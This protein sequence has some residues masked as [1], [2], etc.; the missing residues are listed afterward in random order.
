MLCSS[1]STC[2]QRLGCQHSN[3]TA[4]AWPG[5]ACPP[6]PAHFCPPS[7]SARLPI[8][9]NLLHCPAVHVVELG[10]QSCSTYS[11]VDS[12]GPF[13][14]GA[15]LPERPPPFPV[16]PPY[17][18]PMPITPTVS[19]LMTD[20]ICPLDLSCASRYPSVPTCPLAA[21]G[22]RDAGR[23]GLHAPILDL[24]GEEGLHG[25]QAGSGGARGRAL[26]CADAAPRVLS[27]CWRGRAGP[28]LPL[29]GPGP[30][31]RA[32]RPRRPEPLRALPHRAGGGERWG[33]GGP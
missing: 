27:G 20:A 17:M 1:G 8:G 14:C 11:P 26:L 33:F 9:T 16:P 24:D 31:R 5:S 3:A 23:Q 6:P 15:H 22:G 21:G 18:T 29:G 12:P 32:A 2:A 7:V 4:A 10:A 25:V 30:P 13:P 28:S 19:S